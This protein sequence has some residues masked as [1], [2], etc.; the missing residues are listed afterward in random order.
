MNLLNILTD[1]NTEDDLADDEAERRNKKQLENR[2]HLTSLITGFILL[3]ADL[4]KLYSGN[5]STL[6]EILVV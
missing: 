2:R 5:S 4:A 3:C 1:G 6:Q